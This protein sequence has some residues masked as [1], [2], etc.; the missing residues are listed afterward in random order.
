MAVDGQTVANAYFL[1]DGIAS[2]VVTTEDG[3]T[4][5]AGIVSGCGMVGIPILQHTYDFDHRCVGQTL[6]RCC[7]T[8]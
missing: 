7:A 5:E 8:S 3:K 1:D 2:I 4:V 6:T